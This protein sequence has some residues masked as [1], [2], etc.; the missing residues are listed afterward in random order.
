MS[1]AASSSA[2][3]VLSLSSVSGPL[4]VSS[5]WSSPPSPSAASP[6]TASSTSLQSSVSS[7]LSASDLSPSSSPSP[8]LS[9]PA[10]PVDEWQSALSPSASFDESALPLQSRTVLLSG[11]DVAAKR[12]E[13][14]HYFHRT[15]SLYESLFSLLSSDESFYEQ[16]DR[17]RHPLIFYFGHTAVFFINKLVLARLLRSDQRVDAN[18]EATCAIGVDEMSWDDWNAAHYQ[19]PTVQRLRQYRAEVRRVVDDV[20]CNMELT[21]PIDWSSAGWIV[22][23]GIEHERIHLETSSVLFRQLPLRHIKPSALFPLC[24]SA[25]HSVGAVPVNRLVRVPAGVA[26]IGKRSDDATYGWDNEYGQQRS[27]VQSFQAAS[28]LV[29]NAEYLQF[30]ES[31]GYGEQQWWGDEGWRYKTFR[32]LEAP[33]FWVRG[34]QGEWRYRAICEETAMPWDW[35]VD[36]NYLEAKA[37]CRWKSAQTGSIVRLPTEDEWVLMRDWAYP[38]HDPVSG[39]ENDQPYWPVAPGNINLEHFASASPIDR[40]PFGQSGLHDVMGNV[41]QHTETPIAGLTGFRYHPLYD[42][43][44]LPT[45]DG[46]HNL[47]VGG[48]FISTGNESLRSARY[49]FRRHFMQHAGFRYIVAQCEPPAADERPTM[50]TDLAVA[51]TLHEHYATPQPLGLPN[52]HRTLAQQVILAVKAQQASGDIAQRPLSIMELGC[53][54]GRAAFELAMSGLFNR[55]TAIDRTTRLIRLASHLQQQQQQQQHCSTSTSPLQYCLTSEGELQSVH[56]AALSSADLPLSSTQL[57]SI[58]FLQDDADNMKHNSA[59]LYDV[60]LVNCQLENMS[61][62]TAFLAACHTRLSPGGVLLVACSFQWRDGVS[63]KEEWLGGRR[64]N[65]EA[66]SGTRALTDTLAPHFDALQP[67]VELHKLQR[68]NARAATLLTVHVS[69]WTRHR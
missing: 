24:P 17:L 3:G 61:R 67:P 68:H 26:A 52:F 46:R 29:S 37:F 21:L 50:E 54:V 18:I 47:I 5:K 15:F 40:F 9:Q 32:R 36:V 22:L 27:E 59:T 64:E 42:D 65:G 55:I 20:I 13:L 23:M 56:E 49:A 31:G 33:L 2:G 25:R 51:A 6:S 28:F 19:W 62:P 8:S 45:F 58:A 38:L 34:A 1:R 43:F 63:S 48:S 10:S 12:V 35:P 4:R 7:S 11:S 57:A 66:I 53:G 60:L 41:W 30:V 69:S 39:A 16:P 14:R 44:S